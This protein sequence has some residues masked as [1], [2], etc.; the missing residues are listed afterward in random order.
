[1]KTIRWHI[2]RLVV[3]GAV[4]GL[5]H[6]AR[7]SIPLPWVV[8]IGVG[9][10]AAWIPLAEYVW[11]ALFWM[12]LVVLL[13]SLLRVVL[14]ILGSGGRLGP[15]LSFVD[16]HG[17]VRT[18]LS[19]EL[20]ALTGRIG[21]GARLFLGALIVLLLTGIVGTT[22][23]LD[24][25]EGTFLW[26]SR[27]SSDA[28]PV[29][30]LFQLDT[31]DNNVVTYLRDV[32]KV[33]RDLTA[34]GARVILAQIPVP[35]F[36]PGPSLDSVGVVD[37]TM[38][39]LYADDKV[40][41]FFGRDTH[42]QVAYRAGQLNDSATWAVRMTAETPT[43][44]IY[45]SPELYR[46]Y[47]FMQRAETRWYIPSEVNR[48]DVS[49]VAAGRY[50]GFPATLKPVAEHH[51][52]RFGNL[53]IP[54]TNKGVA[55]APFSIEI[56]PRLLTWFS[57]GHQNGRGPMS[58]YTV[59]G[60]IPAGA[61]PPEAAQEVAGKIV[62]LVWT[63]PDIFSSAYAHWDGARA[64]CQ[65]IES[66]VAGSHVTKDENSAIILC[67]VITCLSALLMRY[68]RISLATSVTLLLSMLILVL[69]IMEYRSFH[70]LTDVAYPVL[71]GVL[72]MVILPLVRLSYESRERGQLG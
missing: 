57:S 39:S 55:Y 43:G 29:V 7:T 32:R 46:W 66:V 47:P 42:V 40:V 23:A 2:I 52:V 19:D 71:A 13:Y 72:S 25:L 1:M 33:S 58:Y 65:I 70:I 54:V 48:I 20:R 5:M 38:H 22:G 50:F 56:F 12:V 69:G 24:D 68:A 10:T 8:P 53:D 27:G 45:T 9:G 28:Q 41:L 3:T 11:D 49:L 59:R 62:F 17:V 44:T 67:L 34:A 21:L 37:S 64:Y 61:L 4:L 51:H 36:Y 16:R 30:K 35:G 31:P 14:Y 6:L 60:R 63:Y 18:F 26:P 15:V